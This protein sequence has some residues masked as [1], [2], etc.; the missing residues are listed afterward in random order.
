MFMS[1]LSII[2][3]QSHNNNVKLKAY[4]LRGKVRVKRKKC[5]KYVEKHELRVQIHKLRV[6][7]LEL[8]D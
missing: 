3:R 5:K 8:E 6:Q 2:E 1:S 4:N 7:I